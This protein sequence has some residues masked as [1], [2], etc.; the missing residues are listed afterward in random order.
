MCTF[1]RMRLCVPKCARRGSVWHAQLLHA[2]L[3]D[4]LLARRKGPPDAPV[5]LYYPPP[6]MG[7]AFR[8]AVCEVIVSTPGAEGPPAY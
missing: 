5:S 3:V 1:S 8:H 4:I 7:Y 6:Y 2:A